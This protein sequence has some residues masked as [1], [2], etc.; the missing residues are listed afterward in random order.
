MF[1]K[2]L[3]HL[4]RHKQLGA[5]LAVNALYKPFYTLSY[6][7]A[8]KNSGL[9]NQLSNK[10][11]PFADLATG[12][13]P[14][15]K[16]EEAL[17]AWLQMGCR[18][19]LLGRSGQGYALKGLAKKLA[20]PENDAT[21]ALAQEVASLHHRLI[22]DT[23]ARLGTGELWTLDNQD[24]DLTTRSSRALEAFQLEA[25]DRFLPRTGHCRLLEIGCGSGIYIRHAA[26]RN[27]S[28]TAVGLELQ[29]D[30]ADVARANIQSWALHG[31]VSIETGDIRARPVS[32]DFDVATLYNNIYYFQVDE[33]V[34]LLSRIKGMLKPGGSLLL[35]T[36][37]Q[38]GNLGMEALNLWGASNTQGG[39]LPSVD[40][41]VDQ[42]KQAGY[43]A[44]DTIKLIPGGGFHAFHAKA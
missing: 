1:L 21:L 3:F 40:E 23:P 41:M 42:M 11:V 32:P 35:T 31:Q 39:R 9:M 34:A 4:L 7:A 6:L 13:A 26:L 38:G 22:V 8:L 30:A 43:V 28:L 44:V 14:G 15:A 36:C 12:F 20:R 37:C 18:L 25:V 17:E 16:V 2:P 19:G 29:Q 24:G 5:A 10:T 27:P 33:R